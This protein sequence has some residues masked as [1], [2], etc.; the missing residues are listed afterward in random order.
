MVRKARKSICKFKVAAA[1]VDKNGVVVNIKCNTPRISRKGGGN[2]AEMIVMRTS[3]R[4]LRKIII[5]RIS[6]NDNFAAIEPCIACRRKAEELGIQIESI[7]G[8]I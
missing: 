6:S 8:V 1:G 7:R 3:P 4:S 5:C 2:H